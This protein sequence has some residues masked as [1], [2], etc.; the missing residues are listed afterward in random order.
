MSER[1]LLK[2][3]T[4]VAVVIVV[5]I[6]LIFFLAGRRRLKGFFRFVPPITLAYFLPMAMTTAGVLPSSS[7]AYSWITENLLPASLVLLIVTTDIPSIMRLGPKALAMML[8]GTAGVM[9]GGPVVLVLFGNWLPPASWKGVAALAGSW[10]GGSVNMMAVAEGIGTPPDLLAPLIVVDT[11]VGYTWFGLVIYLSSYQDSMDRWLK[12]DRSVIDEINS[13]LERERKQRSRPI[14]LT[15]LAY[16]LA[17]AFGVGRVCFWAG[18][19]LPEAGEIVGPF[20]WTIILV[21]AVAAALSFT[22]LRRLEDAGASRLGYIG[23]YIVLASIGARADV[24]AVLKT[25]L[26]FAAGVIWIMIHASILVLAARLLRAPSFLFATASMAN[27]GGTSTGPI[28]ASVYQS[29]MAPVGLLLAVF[30][31]LI[32]TYA[33][34]ICAQLCLLVAG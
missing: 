27:V 33:A 26:F 24:G 11:V 14:T 31:M 28:T 7:P 6:G 21:T 12:A 10:I 29:A 15:D 22:P 23:I 20:T 2:E 30:G 1:A 3:S 32:G 13:R 18:S 4:S 8:A 17:L 25:P 5:V 34:L 16:M 9:I 19:V